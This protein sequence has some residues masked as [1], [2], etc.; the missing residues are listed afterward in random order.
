MLPLPRHFCLSHPISSLGLKASRDKEQPLPEPCSTPRPGSKCQQLFEY[1]CNRRLDWAR[2]WQKGRSGPAALGKQT[3]GFAKARCPGVP[4]ALWIHPGK[5]GGR[6]R[7]VLTS[8]IQLHH[9]R[10]NLFCFLP[11]HVDRDTNFQKPPCIWTNLSGTQTKS[12][13][14]LATSYHNC[15]KDVYSFNHQIKCLIPLSL[16]PPLSHSTASFSRPVVKKI[17]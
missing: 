8:N 2:N 7:Y 13:T 9:T 16:S 1:W 3:G 10:S 17:H 4:R 15:N 6:S 14:P 5:N 12:P 11:H